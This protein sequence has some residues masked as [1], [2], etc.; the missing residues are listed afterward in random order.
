MILGFIHGLTNLGG[1]LLSILSSNISDN[2]NIIRYNMASGYF[3]FAILQ[4]LFVNILFI[5]FGSYM[6]IKSRT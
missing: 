5:S 1:I 4:I 2:K 3:I 6:F